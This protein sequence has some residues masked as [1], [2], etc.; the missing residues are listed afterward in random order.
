MKRGLLIPLMAFIIIPGLAVSAQAEIS[1]TQVTT[2]S[3]EDSSPHI[4]G[5]HLVWQGEVDGD[6]EI[7]LY[8][9]ATGEG[10]VQITHNRF[11]DISPQ[12]D[13]NHVV[14]LGFSQPDGPDGEIFLP[15]GEVFLYN[16]SNG[17]TTRITN[18]TN[19][20]SPPQIA[21][22]KV[23]WASHVVGNSVEPG[24]IF[25]YDIATGVTEQL[26]NNTLDDSS[27]RINAENVVW[28]HKNS[29][30]TT[31]LFVR[32]LTDGST[33]PAPPGFVWPDSPQK[34]GDLMVLA[35][36]DGS[37]REIF[38]HSAALGTYEQITDN[39]LEDR[40]PLIS[41]RNIA[42]VGGKGK[43]SEIFWAFY[44]EGGVCYSNSDCGPQSY[45][46]KPEG[47]CDGEGACTPVPEVC[48][49]TY[50]PVCG[51]DGLTYPS[52]CE[53][54]MYGVSVAHSGECGGGGGTLCSILGDDPRPYAPDMDVFKFSGT[55]GESVTVVL[56]SN[57]PEYGVGQRAVL[58]IRSLGRGLRLFKRLNKAL[59]AEMTVTLPVS[60]DY[61]VKVMEARGRPVIWGKKYEGDYCVTLEASPETVA[62]FAPDLAIE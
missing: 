56:E 30:G 35:R 15:G 34:D 18:D 62:T 51:C 61:H 32:D 25:L 55:E 4:V 58:I 53:A 54:A 8:N 37:D 3:Y 16:I 23:V 14:W 36:F 38:V 11:D 17:Q 20:D 57:P 10:P 40:Y 7:F 42:W 2:N 41:G 31:T 5:N 45:C 6:W 44:D 33:S 24:E 27:P 9:V 39:G 13:G 50:D 26:T 49:D 1:I 28:V 52:E 12:T 47:D 48:L 29:D 60:G 21:D 59:P 22:G 19:V 46:A 43:A